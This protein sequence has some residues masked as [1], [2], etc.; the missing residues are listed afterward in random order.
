[1]SQNIFNKRSSLFKSSN[2]TFFNT[3]PMLNTWASK[4]TQM[5]AVYQEKK[6]VQIFSCVKLFATSSLSNVLRAS[7]FFLTNLRT[8]RIDQQTDAAPFSWWIIKDFFCHLRIEKLSF[9][10]IFFLLL[11][12]CQFGNISVSRYAITFPN[13]IDLFS[14]IVNFL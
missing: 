13:F 4:T 1:M 11:F 8:I 12:S 3:Y 5:T 9:F 6:E 10:F 7:G 14:T 2:K